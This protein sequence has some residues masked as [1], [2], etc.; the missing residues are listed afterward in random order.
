MAAY[1]AVHDLLIVGGGI[2]GAGIACDAA[3]RGLSVVL[4][5]QGD[6]AG[7]TSSAS[8]KLIHGGLRYLEHGEFRLVRESLAE[9][10]VLLAKAP[11]IAR[12]LDFVLPL[13]PG[14][15]PAWMIRLALMVYDRLAD[16]PRLADSRPVFLRRHAAGE[17]LRK[18]LRRGFV[19]SDCWVDDARLVV[20]NALSA[21]ANGATVLTGTRLV[22]AWRGDAMWQARL[23][24]TAGGGRR[25]VRARVLVNAAGPWV[26]EVR[27]RIRG[28]GRGRTLRLVKGSHM[29]VPRLHSGDHAYIL[30]NTDR[31]VVFVLPYEGRY[32]LIGTTEV[33]FDGLPGVVAME[34]GEAAYLCDAV[35]RYFATPISPGDAVWSYSGIRPLLDDDAGNPSAVSRD[36][37]LD[38]ETADGAAP[39]LTVHGGKITTYRR[40]A[41]QALG[42]LAPYLPGTSKAW[43]ASA[44]LPGGD[45]PGEDLAAYAAR[46]AAERPGLD[47]AYLGALAGRHGTLA[48]TVLG[49]AAG[50]GDLGL[51]FGGGLRQREVD[52]LVA[53][54]WARTAEDILWRRTKCGLHMDEVARSRLAAYLDG[55]PSGLVAMRS[56]KSENTPATPHR[57]RVAARS[58]RSTTKQRSA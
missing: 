47:A 13:G 39:L 10:E 45:L 5:E 29:V 57:Y 19:Y 35:N 12:P 24:D 17:P 27:E 56:G 37:R 34:P 2:N 52:Y 6:L 38:L 40:L 55:R 44:P 25:T 23:E 16:H 3:G 28:A 20:L 9:R 36:Y 8:S 41:E 48:E 7:G 14:A 53:C 4:C 50:E 54:E 15:R 11:H 33:A 51:D 1:G 26:G 21:A 18:S 22:S 32:S 30:Q 43:T 46:L 31:R 42:R 49:D 58:G